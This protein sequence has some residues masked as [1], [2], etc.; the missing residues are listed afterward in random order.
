MGIQVGRQDISILRY[1]DDNV[2][3]A[4]NK[5]RLPVTVVNFIKYRAEKRA[6][7]AA[8]YTDREG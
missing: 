3:I 1:D 5:E 8:L 2:L 6:L 4:G 7:R